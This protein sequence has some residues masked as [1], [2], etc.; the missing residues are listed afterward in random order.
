MYRL[1]YYFYL[2][3]NELLI[4]NIAVLIIQESNAKKS[5]QKIEKVIDYPLTPPLSLSLCMGESFSA[6]PPF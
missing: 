1:N 6:G 4:W 5:D 2:K 3:K